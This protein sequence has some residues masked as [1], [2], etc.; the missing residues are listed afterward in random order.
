MVADFY[1]VDRGRKLVGEEWQQVLLTTMKGNIERSLG[2][3]KKD[4][5]KALGDLGLVAKELRGGD[6]N[7]L[8]WIELAIRQ[9]HPII[10]TCRIPYRGKPVGHY[11]IIVGIDEDYFYIRDP[12]PYKGKKS[13][14]YRRIPL[15]EF[16]KRRSGKGE[17]VW[18]RLRWG[19]EV[20]PKKR[21]SR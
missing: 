8:A 4:L 6:Q 15:K 17:T 16:M 2:T 3:M 11:V 13:K 9:G 10:V 1:K 18:G 21:E 7:R 5:K 12:F 19:I 20:F 14:A